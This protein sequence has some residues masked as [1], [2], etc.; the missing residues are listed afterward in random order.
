MQGSYLHL[1]SNTA[2]HIIHLSKNIQYNFFQQKHYLIVVNTI[3]NT[4]ITTSRFV[5]FTEILQYKLNYE[6]QIENTSFCAQNTKNNT[7]TLPRRCLLV[8]KTGHMAVEIE[9]LLPKGFHPM[10]EGTLASHF[11]R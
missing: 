4:N 6:G 7:K 5:V 9:M 2:L 3:L 1:I 11:H 8:E 10:E